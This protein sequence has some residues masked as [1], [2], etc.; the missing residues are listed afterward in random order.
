M[1]HILATAAAVGLILYNTTLTDPTAPEPVPEPIREE[2]AVTTPEPAP[3]PESEPEPE[4]VPEEPADEPKHWTAVPVDLTLD[5][6]MEKVADES[7]LDELRAFYDGALFIGD[8]RTAGFDRFSHIETADYF[9]STGMTTYQVLTDEAELNDGTVTTLD[10]M[11]EKREH[12]RIFIMLGI[13]EM[14]DTVP[15]IANQYAVVVDEL[16]SRDLGAQLIVMANM[17]VTSGRSEKDEVFN[18]PRI[19]ELN[20]LIRQLAADRGLEYLDVNPL[21][22]DESG[23]LNAEYTFDNTHVLGKYYKAWSAWIYE[24]LKG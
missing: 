23:Q 17:H 7:Y 16:L 22:D 24:S 2:I 18:N 13:N 10:E 1:R 14:G 4:P 11:L 9:A 5:Q 21:F 6:L 8:S 15:N 19:D 3:V 12:D 20:E